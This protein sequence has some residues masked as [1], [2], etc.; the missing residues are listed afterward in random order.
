[1]GCCDGLGV[2]PAFK[3]S[4]ARSVLCSCAQLQLDV[5]APQCCAL[6]AAGPSVAADFGFDPLGLSDPEGAGGFITPEWLAYS[7]VSCWQPLAKLPCSQR[8]GRVTRASAI[9]SNVFA[10]VG[11]LETGAAD[12]LLP[13]GQL[14]RARRCAAAL[15]QCACCP[16]RPDAS[17]ARPPALAA[18]QVIHG[19]WAML[20]AAGFLAPEI[21]ASA[22]VIPATPDEAVWFR[23][24]VIPPAGQ[25][26]EQATGAM[27]GLQGL[28]DVLLVCSCC[29]QLC[30][31]LLLDRP[32]LCASRQRRV[33]ALTL[34]A[35]CAAVPTC[36]RQVLGGPLHPV[37]D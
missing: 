35:L 16:P 28:Q 2:P 37:L 13:L 6:P 9:F 3:W 31:A 27:P 4:R 7:E 30:E 33:R 15:R 36:R 5:A 23:S 25:Y 34:G 14:G 12:G 32:A 8:H 1:M 18:W 17:A 22:G 26:G 29:E 11:W 10:R 24:G 19:R 21:L 20:G